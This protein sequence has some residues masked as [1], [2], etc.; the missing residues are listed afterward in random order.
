VGSHITHLEQVGRRI[1]E[2]RGAI[3]LWEVRRYN[4]LRNRGIY[5]C[6]GRLYQLG[7]EFLIAG[8]FGVYWVEPWV[9]GPSDC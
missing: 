8:R 2:D 5:S 4:L 9:T 3:A 7:A 1:S 6:R